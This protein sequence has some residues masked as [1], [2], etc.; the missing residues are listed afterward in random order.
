MEWGV[1][2]V[3]CWAGFYDMK[4]K[5]VPNWLTYG[6]LVAALCFHGVTGSVSMSL[7][8]A[9]MGLVWFLIPYLL[10]GMGAGD[11]KLLAATGAVVAWPGALNLVLYSSIA[12]GV[13]VI[14]LAFKGIDYQSFWLA[15]AGGP[16]VFF[17]SIWRSGREH[18]K[19]KVPYALSI[20]VGYAIY[21]LL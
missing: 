17:K 2:A 20:A 12:G 9:V 10:G 18:R 11:V 8:G 21:L 4:Y 19:E 13:L 5:K 14:A 3:V 7:V 16:R 1:L 15:L 6:L